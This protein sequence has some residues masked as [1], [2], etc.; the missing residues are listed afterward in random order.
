MG[1]SNSVTF[2]VAAV[3]AVMAGIL[4][5]QHNQLAAQAEQLAANDYQLKVQKDQMQAQMDRLQAPLSAG[6]TTI[7]EE[8]RLASMQELPDIVVS[9]PRSSGR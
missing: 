5:G 9:A 4:I 2:S 6:S 3:I 8:A 7:R 1:T